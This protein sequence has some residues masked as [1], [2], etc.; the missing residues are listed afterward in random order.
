MKILLI[1]IFII[2]LCI[3]ILPQQG[4]GR[5]EGNKKILQLEKVKLLETLDLDDEKAVKFFNLR[6]QHQKN[7]TE[8]RDKSDGILDIMQETLSG[9]G[10]TNN[11]SLNRLVEDFKSTEAEINR[12]RERYL[13]EAESLLKAD[14][15]AKLL[16]FERNFRAEVRNLIMEHRMK[17]PGRRNIND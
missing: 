3:T 10:S 11:S 16:V 9:D 5:M 7:M 1:N 14:K 6:N 12:E 15:F 17:R 4:R 2:V 13:K 8:L